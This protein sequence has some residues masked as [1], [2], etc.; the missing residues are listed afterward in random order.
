MMTRTPSVA[1]TLTDCGL[2][3]I[4]RGLFGNEGWWRCNSFKKGCRSSVLRVLWL[5]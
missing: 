4:V 1:L 2:L 3:E 5:C